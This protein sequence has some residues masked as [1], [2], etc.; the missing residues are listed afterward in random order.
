MAIHI[1][2]LQGCTEANLAG[3][4]GSLVRIAH[5]TMHRTASGAFLLRVESDD[6]PDGQV[7]AFLAPMRVTP[8]R[9]VEVPFG[10]VTE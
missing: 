3:V 1:F 8:V 2:E 10:S 6:S 7:Q 5:C 4:Q 9:A